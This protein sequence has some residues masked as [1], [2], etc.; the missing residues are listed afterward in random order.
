VRHVLYPIHALFSIFSLIHG[1]N[2]EIALDGRDQ[3]RHRAEDDEHKVAGQ[4]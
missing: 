2:P 3:Q 4:A 1:V